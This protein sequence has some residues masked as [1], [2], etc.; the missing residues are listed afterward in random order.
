MYLHSS[1]SAGQH[2]S[3]GPL[4]VPGMPWNGVQA[5]ERVKEGMGGRGDI[6]FYETRPAL[7]KEKAAFGK[8]S[9]LP[10]R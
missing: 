10:L 7:H 9:Q 6:L 5:A 3:T 1:H 4:A 8:T 2:T